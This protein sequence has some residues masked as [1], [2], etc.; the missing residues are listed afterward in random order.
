M[1]YNSPMAQDT[2]ASCTR[3]DSHSALVKFFKYFLLYNFLLM[4]IWNY[5]AMNGDADAGDDDRVN[6]ICT[7]SS[8]NRPEDWTEL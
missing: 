6:F 7:L 4:S 5:G 2:F 1:K 8:K 3:I